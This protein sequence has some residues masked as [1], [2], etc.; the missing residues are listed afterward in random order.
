[1]SISALTVSNRPEWIPFCKHQVQ[2]QTLPVAEHIIIDGTGLTIG[3]AR[4][5]ALEVASHP[6]VAWFDDDDWASPWRIERA[7]KWFEHY[8]VVAVGNVSGWM[9]STSFADHCALRYPGYG[10]IIFNGG[11]FRANRMPRQF[12]PISNGEDVEWV[13]G[14]LDGAYITI[15]EIQHAWLCHEKNQVNKAT[16][17]TFDCPLPPEILITDWERR[18]IP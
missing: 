4:T 7:A 18:L 15:G 13:R 17:H 5:K 11:V 1:M 9:V 2:K 3:A 6:L 8:E 10:N 16:R 14:G 12:Q